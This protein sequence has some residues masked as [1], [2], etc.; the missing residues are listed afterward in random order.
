MIIQ[1]VDS[2]EQFKDAF[3]SAGRMNQFSHEGLDALFNYLNEV[4]Q[5]ENYELDVI[6]LCCDF[7]EF[8]TDEL[9]K[10]YSHINAESV[11]WILKALNDRTTLIPV[12]NGSFIVGAF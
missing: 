4:Y 5:N 10:E 8:T 12:S 1:T 7:S 9:L 11:H 6:A 3:R 2:V